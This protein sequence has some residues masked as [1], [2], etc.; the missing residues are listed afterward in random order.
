M[1][2]RT[3]TLNSVLRKNRQLVDSVPESIAAKDVKEQFLRMRKNMM[4]RLI[5]SELRN[6]KVSEWTMQKMN[7]V[8][9]EQQMT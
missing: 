7:K 5:H 9:K 2:S 6:K 3:K 1:N 4:V 8:K